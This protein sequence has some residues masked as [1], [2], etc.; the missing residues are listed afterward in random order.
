MTGIQ[1]LRYL[2]SNTSL[3]IS[4]TVVSD[5]EQILSVS[6]EASFF[7]SVQIPGLEVQEPV[8]ILEATL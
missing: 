4:S 5:P 2:Q 3:T 1:I 7:L 6:D 8:I